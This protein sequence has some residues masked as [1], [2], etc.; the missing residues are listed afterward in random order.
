MYIQGR[1]TYCVYRENV[2]NRLHFNVYTEKYTLDMI[3]A[4]KSRAEN[5]RQKILG[6]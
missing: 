5:G 6:G 2:Y 4:W 3:V 1:Q